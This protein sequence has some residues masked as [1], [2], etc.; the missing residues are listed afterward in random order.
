[1][2]QILKVQATF[3]NGLILNQLEDTK[4]V[5]DLIEDIKYIVA[6]TKQFQKTYVHAKHT[7]L[8]ALRD[9]IVKEIMQKVIIIDV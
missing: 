9:N 3:L 8:L 5:D 6:N 1:M 4:I 2:R 7:H